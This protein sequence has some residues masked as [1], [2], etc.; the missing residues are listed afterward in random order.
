MKRVA[1]ASFALMFMLSAIVIIA[2]TTE[3][4]DAYDPSNERTGDLVVF[5]QDY[6]GLYHVPSNMV[7]AQETFPYQLNNLTLQYDYSA[8][9]VD[10]NATYQR[11]GN[12]FIGG[13]STA[14]ITNYS[15]NVTYD[16][17][18]QNSVATIELGNC[19]FAIKQVYISSGGALCQ[20]IEI[21][22]YYFLPGDLVQY[23]KKW[24]SALE[25][26]RT[27]N[28]RL[29]IYQ[30]NI[31]G[32]NTYYY[33]DTLAFYAPTYMSAKNPSAYDTFANPT[34][35][36][37]LSSPANGEYVDLKIHEIKQTVPAYEY[38]T[39]ISDPKRMSFGVDG[40]H[41]YSTVD[42]GFAL[43]AEHNFTG[44][45][46]VGFPDLSG[47]SEEN[48]SKLQEMFDNGWELGL[49]YTGELTDLSMEAAIER[50]NNEYEQAYEMFGKYPTSFCS[51]RNADNR[52]H[53]SYA[54]SNLGIIWRNGP[55][56]V[57]IRANIGNLMN[58]MWEDWWEPVSAA[59]VIFPTFTHELDPDPSIDFSITLTN[60]T[61]FLENYETAGVK[62]GPW[63]DYWTIAQN[64]YYSEISDLSMIN[65]SMLSLTL[66][67]VG[68]KSRLLINADF[69][70][71]VLDEDGNEVEFEVT[72]DGIIIE[73]DAGDY[74]MMTLSYYRQ[75]QMNNAITP[76][77][78]IIPLVIILSVIPMVMGLGRKLK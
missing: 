50:M 11:L 67:N 5:H 35:V 44:T 37:F 36:I 18:N 23:T 47:Y 21:T 13:F 49:H 63:Y 42:D 7:L 66:D 58:I 40:P 28:V 61:A 73:V 68:G 74:R 45:I 2:P 1:A 46:W 9:A 54:Y 39:P 3:A 60:F 19:K 53:A 62:I 64:T 27:G 10:L 71:I 29:S 78:A 15:L 30:D 59:G 56:G 6:S 48:I 33:N 4:A 76:I 72:P 25:Y 20:K 52:S 14:L 69:V 22:S 24:T 17:S 65:D 16:R 41:T 38:I 43:M 75:E 51:L 8:E 26:Y 55:N 31:N 57:H 32:T 12:L 70:E 34:G 77:F